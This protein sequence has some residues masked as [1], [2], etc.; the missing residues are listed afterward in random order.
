MSAGTSAPLSSSMSLK[1][2]P[3]TAPAA[4]AR[5]KQAVTTALDGTS[6]APSGGATD[7]R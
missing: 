6:S 5:E 1:V 4:G 3:E 2:S 7:T